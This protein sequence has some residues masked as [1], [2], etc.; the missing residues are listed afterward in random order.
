[1]ICIDACVRTVSTTFEQNDLGGSHW[2]R[3]SI[4]AEPQEAP[5]A[6]FARAGLSRFWVIAALWAVVWLI[7]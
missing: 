4:E 2:Q 5:A 7:W 3:H 1:M 6:A